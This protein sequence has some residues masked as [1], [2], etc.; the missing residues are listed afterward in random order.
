MAACWMAGGQRQLGSALLRLLLSVD[1]VV[2]RDLVLAGTH[3]CEFDL[4]LNILHVNGAAG[5]HATHES[6]LYH[7]G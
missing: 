3:Q 7:V 1:N 5:G 4:V 2:P 6:R